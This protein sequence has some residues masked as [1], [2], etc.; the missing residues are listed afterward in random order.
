MPRANRHFLPGHVWHLTH[1]CS[2]R[3]STS[4]EGQAHSATDGWVNASK[5]CCT[6]FVNLGNQEEGGSRL[7]STANNLDAGLRRHD[8]SRT[9]ICVRR[10]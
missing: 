7:A 1:R 5:K 2:S 9:I 8:E 4:L 10:N 3:L 6:S